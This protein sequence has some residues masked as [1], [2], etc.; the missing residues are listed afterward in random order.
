[1]VLLLLLL[2]PSRSSAKP[3]SSNDGMNKSTASCRCDCNWATGTAT[4]ATASTTAAL[5]SFTFLRRIPCITLVTLGRGALAAAASR[6]CASSRT[7]M[8]ESREG[9]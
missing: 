8:T 4:S 5:T 2:P 3:I 7:A 6:S 9:G 1:M